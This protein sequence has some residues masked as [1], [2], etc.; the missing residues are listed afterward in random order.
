VH[1][2]LAS[3]DPRSTINIKNLPATCGRC[4]PG[5]GTRFAIGLVHQLPGNTEPPP[6]K[7]ARIAYGIIIP[8]TIGFMILHNA[9]DWLRK[10]NEKRFRPGA[11]RVK[12]L[13]ATPRRE[14]RMYPF[15]RIQH[16]L[17]VLSFLTLVWTGFA[18]KY[19]DQWWASV[20]VH[21]EGYFP[22]RGVVHRIAAVVLMTVGAMH[23]FSLITS[24]RL[25]EH[26]KHLW[27]VRRDLPEALLN[28]AYNMYLRR[29]RPP[30]SSHSYI[31]KAEYWAVVWGA[32][33]MGITGVMLWANNLTLRFLPKVALD[34]ATTVH[35]YEAVL[36]SLAIV[37][38]HFYSV[39]FDPDVY[40]LE[41]AFLTGVSVKEEEAETW[42]GPPAEDP[43]KK[44]E[45]QAQ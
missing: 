21:W 37:V 34:I 22:V 11:A 18:L 40:P 5:A 6:V 41:T 13:L 44:D 45:H 14:V 15:E 35:F 26:W 39:I 29:E 24:R 42:E 12:E 10:L 2:I 19:P 17:L 3:S 43:G 16:A 38:W 1:N 30:I 8:L 7:W 27:P 32:L 23:L 9:G 28:F 25:R 36:A 4:H 20:L 33:V 31:E